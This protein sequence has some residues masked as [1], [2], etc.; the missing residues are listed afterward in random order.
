[1]ILKL[2]IKGNSFANLYVE[3]EQNMK[4]MGLSGRSLWMW[5]TVPPHL[6]ALLLPEGYNSGFKN[7]IKVEP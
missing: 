4:T 6:M 1:M 5:I 7:D 2:N 3:G